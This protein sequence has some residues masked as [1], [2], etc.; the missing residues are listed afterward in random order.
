MKSPR[1]SATSTCQKVLQYRGGEGGGG[2]CAEKCRRLTG[3]QESPL[4]SS[5][6]K[7]FAEE[8]TRG[9]RSGSSATLQLRVDIYAKRSKLSYQN[10]LIKT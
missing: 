7:S 9:C 6:R 5:R 8:T 10:K 2:G 1:W 4:P 3:S